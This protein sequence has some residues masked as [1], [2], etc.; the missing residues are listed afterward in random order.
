[1]RRL[2]L[3]AL[4]ISLWLGLGVASAHAA[5]RPVEVVGSLA[6]AQLV[7]EAP[8]RFLGATL[9]HASLW[10]EGGAF[11]W[12]RPFALSLVYDRSFSARALADHTLR[13]M[14]RA[15]PLAHRER[16]HARL[17]S[18][19]GDVGRGD[20][21]TGVSLDAHTARFFLNGERR[22]DIEEAGFSRAFF[23][24]WLDASRANQRFS[25]RL[26]GVN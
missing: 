23:G 13:E 26:R 25:Q 15:G 21:I 6:G 22:C 14:S 9:F 2:R 8:Y 16:L 12:S 20:R 10:A 19:F 4:A 17:V 18:C 11:A 24:I 3:A 5:A 7:G 1:M